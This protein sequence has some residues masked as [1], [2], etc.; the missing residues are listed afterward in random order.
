MIIIIIISLFLLPKIYFL[1]LGDT[2]L[3]LTRTLWK[4]QS[5]LTPPP[6]ERNTVKIRLIFTFTSRLWMLKRWSFGF[7]VQSLPKAEHSVMLKN[8]GSRN[9]THVN[10]TLPLGNCVTLSWWLNPS[11]RVLIYNMG[12]YYYFVTLLWPIRSCIWRNQP[13]NGRFFYLL[14]NK[15]V[16]VFICCHFQRGSPI[17]LLPDK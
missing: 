8:L 7:H 14:P 1:L 3:P 13:R 16:D 5:L 10:L 2:F 15:M 9:E 12:I 11:F 4:N 6:P 17:C